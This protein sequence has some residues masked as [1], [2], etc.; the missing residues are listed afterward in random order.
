MR[1]PDNASSLQV[2]QSCL[3]TC[4]VDAGFFWA[5]PLTRAPDSDGGS[6]CYRPRQ[7]CLRIVTRLLLAVACA[8]VELFARRF[9]SR[10][11]AAQAAPVLAPAALLCSALLYSAAA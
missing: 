11:R 5:R 4:T 10:L 2:C 9:A 6:R 7:H 3:C 1:R 8:V